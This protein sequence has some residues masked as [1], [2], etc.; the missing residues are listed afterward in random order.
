MLWDP[1]MKGFRSMKHVSWMCGYNMWFCVRMVLD[2]QIYPSSMSLNRKEHADWGGEGRRREGRRAGRKEEVLE[3]RLVSCVNPEERQHGHPSVC[4]KV[5][6]QLHIWEW[7]K[8]FLCSPTVCSLWS[9][10][11]SPCNLKSV[12]FW[13]G[14]LVQALP[15]ELITTAL[16]WWKL[17][18]IFQENCRIVFSSVIN[19]N[20]IIIIINH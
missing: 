14:L 5:A 4:A 1:L 3:K 9:L 17:P 13:C 10:F 16:L 6:H 15:K 19:I 2:C 11:S 18:L 7:N 20:G 12:D 8:G